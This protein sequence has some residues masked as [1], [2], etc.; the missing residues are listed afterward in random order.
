MRGWGGRRLAHGAST[1]RARAY[2]CRA[3]AAALAAITLLLC[4]ATACILLLL[5][6]ETRREPIERR[7][8]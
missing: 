2:L 1:A 6:T 4:I 8:A 5:A 7:A 3:G